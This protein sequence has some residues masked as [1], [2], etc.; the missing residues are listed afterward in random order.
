MTAPRLKRLDMRGLIAIHKELMARY[1]G[2]P[3]EVD[4]A[5]LELSI[6]RSELM[7]RDPHWKRRARLAAEYGWRILTIRPFAEGNERWRWRRW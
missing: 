1:G 3:R 6:V 4:M 7:V 2:G 5:M